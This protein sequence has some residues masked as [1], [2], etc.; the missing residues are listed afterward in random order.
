MTTRSSG[1]PFP[2]SASH[3]IA[4][5]V[6]FAFAQDALLG[7]AREAADG[8]PVTVG[9]PPAEP[10]EA[11]VGV[12][13]LDVAMG[14]GWSPTQVSAQLRYVVSTWGPDT[15]VANHLLTA[16]LLDA[17]Q[18]G[19]PEVEREPV[20][21]STWQALGRPCRPGFVVSVTVGRERDVGR[22]PRVR[23]P[24]EVVVSGALPIAGQV[25]GPGGVGI[26]GAE[27]TVPGIPGATVISAWDGRF[28]LGL[29]PR[30]CTV[31]VS[32]RG[33]TGQTTVEAA[34]SLPLVLKIGPEEEGDA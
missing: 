12:W 16:M 13:L 23:A 9:L 2:G 17:L 21:A 27:V 6:D 32:A 19:R 31:L 15:S 18:R 26:A 22:A 28:T 3:G 24:L 8:T 5:P 10:T 7:W 14:R 30:P 33:W 11:G 20:S 25:T 34:T 1:V 29:M 4:E